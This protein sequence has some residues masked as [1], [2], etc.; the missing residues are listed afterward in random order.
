ML[1]VTRRQLQVI[2]MISRGFDN[3]QIALALGTERS[4]VIDHTTHIKSLSK[5]SNDRE[6]TLWCA[7]Y[8]QHWPNET[9]AKIPHTIHLVA[10][11]NLKFCSRCDG[12]VTK[13]YF[14]KNK[15]NPD[16]YD[17]LCKYH[18]KVAYQSYKLRVLIDPVMGAR[19]RE[20]QDRYNLIKKQV[21]SRK[22][23]CEA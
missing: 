13:T 16:G 19:F 5:S 17:F 22:Q 9:P 14:Y 11:P 3:K 12:Y 7:W 8:V 1:K 4:T 20:R 21:R 6:L 23:P 10:Q 15:H 2:E 18:R